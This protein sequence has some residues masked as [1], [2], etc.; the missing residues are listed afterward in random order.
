M[1]GMTLLIDDTRNYD[2][3][4]ILRSAKA[5][6]EFFAA[7]KDKIVFSCIYLDFDLVNGTGLDVLKQIMAN[8]VKFCKIKLV[9]F[10]IIGRK[11]MEFFLTVGK[12]SLF[13]FKVTL[14]SL[15]FI[16]DKKKP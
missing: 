15:V 11:Q 1:Q 12:L 14:E 7:I 4:I 9:T 10:N 5:A 2:V 6:I 16:L 13:L 3:D 8:N